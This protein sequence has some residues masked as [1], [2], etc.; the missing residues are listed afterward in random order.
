MKLLPESS[1]FEAINSALSFDTVDGCI[2][3]RLESYSCKMVGQE[4]ALYKRFHSFSGVNDMQALSPPQSMLGVSPNGASPHSLNR[5]SQS[6]GGED[7]PLEDKINRKTL[8]YLIS[9][10]NAAFYPDYDF[11][12]ASSQEFSREPSLE[13]VMR[14]VERQM[15]AV[16]RME[17]TPVASSLWAALD[18]AICLKDCEIYSYN[19]DLTSDPYSEDGCLWSFNYFFYNSRLKRIVFF[20][21]RSVSQYCGSPHDSGLIGDSSM[22]FEDDY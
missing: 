22:D 3:G 18:D 5:S 16:A 11:S 10:L 17:F 6:S 20:T 1:G 21:C 12:N 14:A 4:K 7:S 15:M 19:P 9:T 2:M 13:W 8:F